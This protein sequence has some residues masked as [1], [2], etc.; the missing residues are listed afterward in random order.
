MS[1][2]I[3]HL[4]YQSAKER[5]KIRNFCI[6]YQDRLLYGT[7]IGDNGTGKPEAFQ[8]SVHD[9]WINDWKYFA[10]D[11]EMTSDN[12]D[13]KFT[14]LQLPKDVVNKIFSRNATKWYKLSL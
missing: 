7:D 9:T 6:K 10:T 3:C 11:L 1:A 14:G 4:Q 5:E 2:R 12:F 8:K 13:G